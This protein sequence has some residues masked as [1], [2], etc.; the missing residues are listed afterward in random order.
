MTEQLYEIS[1]DSKN[2]DERYICNENAMDI[3]V[4][5]ISGNNIDVEGKAVLMGFDPGD[6][7]TINADGFHIYIVVL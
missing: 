1:T 4:K 6:A 2:F 7:I 5:Y 3:I